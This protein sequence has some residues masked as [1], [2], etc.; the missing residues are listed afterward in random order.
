MINEIEHG[1]SPKSFS[2]PIPIAHALRAY[3]MPVLLALPI[4]D[5]LARATRRK[6]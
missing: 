4:D 1:A 6:R 5:W 2:A 3:E